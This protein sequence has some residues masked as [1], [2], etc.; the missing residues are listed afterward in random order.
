[1]PLS[2]ESSA[3]MEALRAR[4]D[5]YEEQLRELGKIPSASDAE[6]KLLKLKKLRIKEEMEAL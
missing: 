4:H 6:K 1:M 3:R 2:H 5:M